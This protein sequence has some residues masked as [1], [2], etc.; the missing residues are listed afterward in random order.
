MSIRLAYFRFLPVFAVV[1]T[2]CHG[3]YLARRAATVPAVTPSTTSPTPME[4]LAEVSLA[5]AGLGDDSPALAGSG[6]DDGLET[7]RSPF[8]GAARLRVSPEA[9]IGLAYHHLRGEDSVALAEDQPDPDGDVHGVGMNLAAATWLGD[10]DWLLAGESQL[11]FYRVPYIEERVCVED[12]GIF[13]D[14][15]IDHGHAYRP[16]LGVSVNGGRRLGP[17][18]VYAGLKLEN[19]LS[20]ERSDH[21]YAEGD[22]DSDVELGSIN[23]VASLGLEV[24]VGQVRVR[25]LVY[26]S[27]RD[28]PVDYGPA[29]ALAVGY[30]FGAPRDFNRR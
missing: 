9:S 25:G 30:A 5:H 15:D 7:I 11:L 8:V 17:F 22:M 12:C 13:D 23:L 3:S 6:A 19:H 26:Q 27:L 29:G 4:R 16:V 1:F 28:E 10:G 21:E 24:K 14:D 2:G 20:A 18:V